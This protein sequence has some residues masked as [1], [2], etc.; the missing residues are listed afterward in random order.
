VELQKNYHV[1]KKLNT[2]I[3]A[4][5][6]EESDPAAMTRVE[7]F[8]KSEFP[9]VADPGKLTHEEKEKKRQEVFGWKTW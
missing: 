6:Q 5:A 9:V 3:I 7:N 4:V 2:E 8:V 1:F